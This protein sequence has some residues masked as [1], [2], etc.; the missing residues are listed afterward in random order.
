MTAAICS[1]SVASG[2][3]VVVLVVVV[4]VLVVVDVVLVVDV[5]VDSASVV[6]LS[7]GAT[8]F[9]GAASSPSPLHPAATTTKVATNTVR[10][11]I[12]TVDDGIGLRCARP[13][14]FATECSV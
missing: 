2:T 1:S 4:V 6:V 10:H 9:T 8:E 12:D 13:G 11:R 3:V 14:Q 7:A 5:V